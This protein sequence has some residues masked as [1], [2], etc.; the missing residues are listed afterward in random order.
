[1]PFTRAVYRITLAFLF[2]LCA[3]AGTRAQHFIGKSK[4]KVEQQLRRQIR[5]HDSLQITLTDEGGQLRYRIAPVRVQAAETVYTFDKRGRCR[6]EKVTASCDSCFKK[7]LGHAL[8][9]KKIGWEKI[10]ENQYISSYASRM[11]IE[12]SPEENNYSYTIHRVD[13]SREQ[14]A[15]MQKK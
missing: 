6:S 13:W 8:A 14:Y 1:M 12:L 10:N 2:F 5:Q 11:L 7:F 4:K 3:P 9:Q 15:L